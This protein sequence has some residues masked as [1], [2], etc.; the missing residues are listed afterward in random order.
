THDRGEIITFYSFK[1]GVG[2]TMALAN[3]ATV[4]AQRGKKVLALDFDFEAPGLH[5]YFLSEPDIEPRLEKPRFTPALQQKGVVDLFRELRRQLRDR[6]P[7]EQYDPAAPGMKQTLRAIVS[8]LVRSSAYKYRINLR[9]PNDSGTATIDFIAAGY[10]DQRYV[11][12]V[13]AFGWKRFYAEYAEV[14]PVLAAELAREYDYVLIDSRTGFTDVGSICTMVLPDKLVLVFAPNEQSLTGAL[15][16]GEQAVRERL[17]TD[18]RSPLP[19]FPLI[20]RLD[21][22]EERLKR[23]WIHRARV[24]F[25]SLFRDLY[26]MNARDLEGYFAHARVHHRGYYAYGE[27]IATEEEKAGVAGSMAE[28]FEVFTRR[29][30]RKSADATIDPSAIP[31]TDD[32]SRVFRVVE[33]LSEHNDFSA[34]DLETSPRM[35]SYSLLAAQILGLLTES[36]EVTSAGRSIARMGPEER[37]RA[38]VVQFESSVCGKAW[39]DWSKGRTLVDI[40]PD[41][42]FEFIKANVLD[43]G[44]T[45]ASRRAHTLK[46]WYKTLIPYH[47]DALRSG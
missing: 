26:G 18:H 20:S 17:T 31:Q 23:E 10:F 29:L 36:G 16:V 28:S 8:K 21:D 33:Q 44:E 37:L 47:Y 25:E 4:L 3:V 6:L 1:G 35:R 12:R 15:D 19:L 9:N 7:V 30:N 45:T 27:R 22:S 24:S 2:R 38:A 14:L 5:R 39:I 42:A 32:L 46:T 43:L 40:S 11:E 13:R 34:P 41:T